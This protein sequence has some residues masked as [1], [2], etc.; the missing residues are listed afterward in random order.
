MGFFCSSWEHRW[1]HRASTSRLDGALS[2]PSEAHPRA[3]RKRGGILAPSPAEVASN[4]GNLRHG[5][6]IS[7]R[8]GLTPIAVR[9]ANSRRV[10]RRSDRETGRQ[11][12]GRRPQATRDSSR[13][14]PLRGSPRVSRRSRV[15]VAYDPSV[16]QAFSTYFYRRARRRSSSLTLAGRP[17]RRGD[18]SCSAKT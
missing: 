7:A 1:E 14:A 10:R 16:G 9:G 13:R 4:G 3:V 2:E 17:L 6:S 15:S 5:S 11:G 18:R 12:D 8:S